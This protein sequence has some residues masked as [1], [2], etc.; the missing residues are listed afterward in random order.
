MPFDY[1]RLKSVTHCYLRFA[2]VAYPQVWKSDVSHD[3]VVVLELEPSAHQRE[4]TEVDLPCVVIIP[5]RCPILSL[6]WAP[7]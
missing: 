5:S 1:G 6:N 7:G 3:G 4:V 2:N